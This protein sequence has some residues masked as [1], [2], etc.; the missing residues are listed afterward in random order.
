MVNYENSSAYSPPVGWMAPTAVSTP[1]LTGMIRERKRRR[2]PAVVR[3]RGRVSPQAARGSRRSTRERSG[4]L[5]HRLG[6]RGTRPGGQPRWARAAV[7]APQRT[8]PSIRS[9]RVGEAASPA[10]VE[11]G[12]GER[13]TRG[14]RPGRCHAAVH[15]STR[16]WRE[17]RRRG[18]PR[19]GRR[20]RAPPGAPRGRRG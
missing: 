11:G 15:P 17:R 7:I 14:S 12:G 3:G 8:T 16:G 2:W 4:R 5:I 13:F 20:C 18:P 19:T 6:R 10:A 1:R 9:P